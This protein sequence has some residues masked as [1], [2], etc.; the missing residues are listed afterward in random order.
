M[1]SSEDFESLFIRYKS[2]AYPNGE[3]IQTFCLRNK[4]PY[5]MFEKW[6]RNTRHKI[7]D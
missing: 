1:Y 4:I 2:E 3:S 6:Y 5:N 7:S